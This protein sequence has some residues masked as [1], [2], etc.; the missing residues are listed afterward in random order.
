MFILW[1]PDI[2]WP[3][4]AAFGPHPV[5]SAPPCH[6][7]PVVPGRESEV[8]DARTCFTLNKVTAQFNCF[9]LG[10]MTQWNSMVFITH[11]GHTQ[12]QSTRTKIVG[13]GIWVIVTIAFTNPG[14]VNEHRGLIGQIRSSTWLKIL[15]SSLGHDRLPVWVW[16]PDIFLSV[17]RSDK[18]WA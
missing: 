4:T 2:M 14:I 3:S 7:Y 15:G 12:T 11:D 6:W 8:G 16:A 13:S 17:Y 10:L 9:T 18:P 1:S 5:V